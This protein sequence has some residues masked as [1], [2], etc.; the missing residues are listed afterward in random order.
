M[1]V[2]QILTENGV[3]FWRL[4]PATPDP[5]IT[6]YSA[7]HLFY[8]QTLRRVEVGFRLNVEGQK[9]SIERALSLSTG[10]EDSSKVT[11]EVCVDGTSGDIVLRDAA[12]GSEARAPRASGWLRATMRYKDSEGGEAELL[13]ESGSVLATLKLSPETSTGTFELIAFES[14]YESGFKSV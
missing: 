11:L 2:G 13:D 14:K 5:S 3:T 10:R 6:T 1:V 4:L 8:E 12:T 9:A 7:T